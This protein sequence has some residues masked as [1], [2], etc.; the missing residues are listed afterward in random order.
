[1]NKSKLRNKFLKSRNA[2]SKKRFN[3]QKNFC[4]GL[5]CE[6]KRQRQYK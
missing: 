4:V 5:L 1:M 2:E 3:R 6:T